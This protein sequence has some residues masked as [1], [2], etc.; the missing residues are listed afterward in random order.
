MMARHS[1]S[2]SIFGAQ[3]FEQDHWLE[4]NASKFRGKNVTNLS[5]LNLAFYSVRV[6]FSGLSLELLE[7]VLWNV[8]QV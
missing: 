3:G 4:F 5:V 6:N 2:T 1:S 7:R 8:I